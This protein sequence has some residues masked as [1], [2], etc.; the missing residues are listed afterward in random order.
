[1][2]KYFPVYFLLLF[3]QQSWCQD[4]TFGSLPL[5]QKLGAVVPKSTSS[6]DS[7][8]YRR[9][10]NIYNRL[11]QARGDFRYPVP[12]F[13]LSTE[14]EH[15]AFINYKLLEIQLEVKALEVC[16]SFGADSET[17]IAFLLAHELTHYYEKHGWRNSFAEDF[18]NLKYWKE[19]H[20]ASPL[21]QTSVSACIKSLALIGTKKTI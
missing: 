14:E 12:T 5:I 10:L 4:R 17:A 2:K 1:M 18:K 13:N 21:T 20:T 15:C 3:F 7:I 6:V 19:L 16:N 11:V 8:Q 9:V